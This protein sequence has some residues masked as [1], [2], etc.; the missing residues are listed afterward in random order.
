MTNISRSFYLQDGGKNVN[1]HRYGSTL[2]HRHPVYTLKISAAYANCCSTWQYCDEFHVLRT[3][4]CGCRCRRERAISETCSTA[5]WAA[6]SFCPHHPSAQITST[7]NIVA[8]MRGSQKDLRV[9][10]T[11]IGLIYTFYSKLKCNQSINQKLQFQSN[12]NV[13]DLYADW[14]NRIIIAF[15][16]KTWHHIYS[17]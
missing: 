11:I 7:E 17:K 13:T 14:S 3:H 8:H 5:T 10:N 4:R 1:W 6:F 2:C 12:N 15:R 16:Q 9:W